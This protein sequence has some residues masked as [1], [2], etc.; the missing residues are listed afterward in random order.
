MERN[1]KTADRVRPIIEA[2]EQSINRVRR[3]RLR[4]DHPGDPAGEKPTTIGH[5]PPP[6]NGATSNGS[7][8]PAPS[9]S[10]APA[11]GTPS[12]APREKNEGGEKGPDGHPNPSEQK[13]PPPRLKARPKRPNPFLRGEDRPESSFR[14]RAS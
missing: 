10:A 9:S 7:S 11:S 1:Q 3:E 4:S 8:G 2:M 13:D 14:S 6:T 12:A 5:P